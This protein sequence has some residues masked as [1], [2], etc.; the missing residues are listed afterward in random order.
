MALAPPKFTLG[1]AELGEPAAGIDA[2]V[3]PVAN[4][5]DHENAAEGGADSGAISVPVCRRSCSVA[6]QPSCCCGPP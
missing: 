4:P 5:V 1:A 6:G 2:P 3:A